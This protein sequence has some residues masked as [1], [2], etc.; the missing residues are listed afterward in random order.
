MSDPAEITQLLQAASGGDE[1]AHAALVPV[2][3]E[4]LRRRAGALMRRETPNH[5]LQA[6]AL[7]HEAYLR[8]IQ[9]D[10]ADWQGRAHFFAMA[11]Q[12]MRRILVDHARSRSRDKRGGGVV[13]VQLDE[14]LAI[15]PQRDADV[16]ALDDALQRLAE[17]DPRQAEIVVMRFFGGLTVDEVAAALDVSK[18]TVE[19]EWTMV[20]AWLRRELGRTG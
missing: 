11:S 8:L 12:F 13:R 10:R 9:Q 6:T 1:R 5:T 17:L 20:K 4:E 14:G 2:V 19:A 7:V 3:Y 16:L 18:R 15:S